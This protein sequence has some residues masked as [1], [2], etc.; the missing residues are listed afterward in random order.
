MKSVTESERQLLIV[1]V[2]LSRTEQSHCGWP[3]WATSAT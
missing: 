2:C 3:R 1:M